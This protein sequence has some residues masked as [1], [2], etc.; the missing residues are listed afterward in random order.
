MKY[1]SAI[2]SAASGSVGGLTYSRNKG[3]S[4]CRARAVPTNR[5]SSLQ[6]KFRSVLGS[7]ANFWA[8][9]TDPNR[10]SWLAY[11]DNVLMVNTLGAS[12]KISAL[13]HFVRSNAIRLATYGNT[14]VVSAAPTVYSLGATP[15]L[16][17]PEAKFTVGGILNL[18]V[19]AFISDAPVVAIPNDKILVFVSKPKSATRLG[20]NGILNWQYG[21]S[22]AALASQPQVVVC[23]VALGYNV[24]G[25]QRCDYEVCVS[26]ADGRLS[27]RAKGSVITLP[28][29]P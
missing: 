10:A 14:F 15:I 13:A 18:T 3:G 12:R 23:P 26:R 7:L 21:V 2:L 29:T 4:Y 5:H 25:G 24:L 8:L 19:T 16:T 28:Y 22:V 27:S 1:T 17:L 9:L 20:R 6:E 11:A